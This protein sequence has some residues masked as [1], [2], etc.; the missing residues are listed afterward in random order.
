LN[1]ENGTSK[2]GASKGRE[3]GKKMRFSKGKI[4]PSGMN[5]QINVPRGKEGGIT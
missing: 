2:V 3:R 1:L 4:K 5:H